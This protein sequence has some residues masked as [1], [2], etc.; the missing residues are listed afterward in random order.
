MVVEAR[1]RV[2]CVIDELRVV[3][4]TVLDRRGLG[5]L[6]A[7]A[8]RRSMVDSKSGDVCRTSALAAIASRCDAEGAVSWVGICVVAGTCSFC[9]WEARI[10][11]IKLAPWHRLG[12]DAN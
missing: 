12:W 7:L 1:V 10:I 2:D 3:R 6:N 9:Q 5:E 8:G 4:L 11:G